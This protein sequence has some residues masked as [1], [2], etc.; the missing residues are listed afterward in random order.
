MTSE[1]VRLRIL[2]KV[3]R[4]AELSPRE[5]V[6]V[7]ELA[8]D[9]LGDAEE[10]I[11]T[12]CDLLARVL[13]FD[14]VEVDAIAKDERAHER[15]VLTALVAGR[16]HEHE[17]ERLNAADFTGPMRRTLASFALAVIEI[18]HR[19]HEDGVLAAIACGPNGDP[20]LAIACGV[21][22]RQCEAGPFDLDAFASAVRARRALAEV[23]RAA[24]LLRRREHG[25]AST[26]LR[27]A[28]AL[29]EIDGADRTTSARKAAA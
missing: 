5:L 6:Q 11:E 16:L 15:R 4:L 23:E 9:M 7:V 28:L 18:G 21:E 29:L 22:L 1:A 25:P 13:A 14:A 10:K 3:A 8:L 20:T 26:A 27:A 12:L 2:R 17:I 24:R 19:P